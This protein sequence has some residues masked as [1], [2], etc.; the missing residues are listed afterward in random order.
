MPTINT[1]PEP[2]ARFLAALDD[3][4]AVA[5]TI[6]GFQMVVDRQAFAAMRHS[7]QLALRSDMP[8]Q[9]LLLMI[10]RCA[11]SGHVEIWRAVEP[12]RAREIQPHTLPYAGDMVER[13][14]TRCG[15]AF[16]A[17][18]PHQMS[19]E[20]CRVRKA[21]PEPKRR[22]LAPD[23]YRNRTGTKKLSPE[24]RARGRELWKQQIVTRDRQPVRSYAIFDAG[25]DARA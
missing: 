5:C 22:A 9:P 4:T 16:M 12:V 23:E 25:E 11:G 3:P 18:R 24:D 7:V 20:G 19:C 15:E 6:C 1:L 14:C 13:T 8:T 17:A 21:Q 10:M 2:P